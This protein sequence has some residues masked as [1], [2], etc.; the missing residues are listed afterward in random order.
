MSLFLVKIFVLPLFTK[1]KSV[2]FLFSGGNC[3]FKYLYLI[4]LLQAAVYKKFYEIN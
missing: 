3:S 1:L 4:L 2:L